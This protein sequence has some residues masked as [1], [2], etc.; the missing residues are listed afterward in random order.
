MN[1]YFLALLNKFHN[2]STE[3]GRMTTKCCRCVL[4]VYEQYKMGGG[5][6]ET[7]EGTKNNSATSLARCRVIIPVFDIIRSRI[8]RHYGS[9]GDLDDEGAFLFGKIGAANGS[10]YSDRDGCALAA[11]QNYVIR[12]VCCN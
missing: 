8:S 10:G 4:F 11:I 5:I 1:H 12:P 9:L 6:W 7:L 3:S 2:I